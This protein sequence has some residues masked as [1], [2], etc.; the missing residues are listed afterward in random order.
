MSYTALYRRF[1]PQK[2]GELVG[3]PHISR[4]LSAAIKKDGFV[5]AYL[6]CGPRGTGKTSTAKIL[7]R[8]VNCLSTNA[9]GEPCGVCSA[10][11]RNTR[12][13]SLDILEIDA[14]SNRGIDEIRD[15]RE[16]VKY[17]P[18]LEKYKVYIIDEVH[19]LT[20]PA[21][22]ALLKTLEEPPSHVLFILATTEPHKIPLTVLSRC[23]RFD[24]RR[25][26]DTEVEKH[27]KRVAEAEGY[28]TEQEA[29]ARIA[30]KVEGGLR[31]ALSLLDQCASAGGGQISLETLQM[32]T[33]AAGRD[34]IEAMSRYLTEGATAQ[35]LTGVADL[36][37]S[38][39]DLRQFMHDLL[40]YLRELLLARL[41]PNQQNLPAWAANIHPALLL[42]L[43][44]ALAEG[45]TRLRSSLQPRLT[46]ELTL[47]SICGIPE[48]RVQQTEDKEQ[49][50]VLK[51]SI[52]EDKSRQ[53]EG[54]EQ[55]PVLK[56]SIPED[57]SRQSE[58]REQKPALK[59]NI[60]EDK[61]QK[62]ENKETAAKEDLEQLLRLWPSIVQE[63][64]RANSSTGAYLTQA[65]P[66]AINTNK[67]LLC[68]DAEYA[69]FMNSICK[70]GP[71]RKLVEEQISALFGRSL[72]LEG[73]L[74]QPKK[75]D[76]PATPPEI[77]QTSL[78]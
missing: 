72:S 40:D 2:F 42:K 55:K 23:Q 14:A 12:G 15:L 22:N 3:Q 53:T 9:E 44:S 66:H 34:F 4:T 29:L 25:I 31:D 43:L 21:F 20:A 36:Y 78:F 28:I 62:T 70:R 65:T 46:L 50:P 27:L 60:P 59:S 52:P 45:E 35:L 18:V 13:E 7:A 51:S 39:G 61:S 17:A 54:R 56:S 64:A 26:A 75:E 30:H 69:L 10:C 41:S 8:A 73:M 1:R 74:T 6:F 57:K 47:L 24:F 32:L 63:V 38:G 33:G 77:E 19:M 37:S 58:G 71:S 68:F 16:R 11:L 76:Q 5:H 48:N 67:L 49:K